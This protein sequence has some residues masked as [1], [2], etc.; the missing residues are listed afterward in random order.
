MRCDHEHGQRSGTVGGGNE[1]PD[2]PGRICHWRLIYDT[3][4]RM[5]AV[6]VTEVILHVNNN[7]RRP[8]SA[9]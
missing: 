1:T 8:L 4:A 3:R 7:E 6:P 9:E 5:R 2:V